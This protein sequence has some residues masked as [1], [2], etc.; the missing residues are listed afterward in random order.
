MPGLR[1][2]SKS[3]SEDIDRPPLN[4]EVVGNLVGGPLIFAVHTQHDKLVAPSANKI[5]NEVIVGSPRNEGLIYYALDANR[6]EQYLKIGWSAR[7]RQRMTDLRG[8][9]TSGQVPVVLALEEGSIQ[10][11]QERHRQFMALRSHGE[12]FRYENDLAK[13]VAQ[14]EHPF[15]YLLDRPRLWEFADGWGPIA[16]ASAARLPGVAPPTS[17]PSGQTPY[18]IHSFPLHRFP[19]RPGH[20]ISP[21]GFEVGPDGLPPIDF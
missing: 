14:M 4:A 7:L 19:L 13:F 21:A 3:S 8:L 12:W 6:Q 5:A 1:K 15:S 2:S 16:P 10:Q 18:N 9:T 17:P 11:E 20:S